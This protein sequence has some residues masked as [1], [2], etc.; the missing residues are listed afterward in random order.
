METKEIILDLAEFEIKPSHVGGDR[1]FKGHGPIMTVTAQLM[2]ISDRTLDLLMYMHAIESSPD[3]T[4][5]RGLASRTELDLRARP[6]CDGYYILDVQGR[7]I[8]TYSYFEKEHKEIDVAPQHGG[9]L[10]ERFFIRGD[11]SGNDQP[12]ARAKFHRQTVRIAKAR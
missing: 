2:Q 9:S 5:F 1:E 10:V 7:P 11:F 6:D 4:E 8:N 12:Y 3:Y